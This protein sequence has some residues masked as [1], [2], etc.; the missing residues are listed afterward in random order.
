MGEYGFVRIVEG[1]A[2]QGQT[3]RNDTV[4]ITGLQRDIE[5]PE[6]REREANLSYVPPLPV[7]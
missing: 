1:S 4:E 7:A 2:V 3:W 5:I 6:V